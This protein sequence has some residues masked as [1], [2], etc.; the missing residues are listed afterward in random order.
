MKEHYSVK[1]IVSFLQNIPVRKFIYRYIEA[2]SPKFI[3]RYIE[4]FFVIVGHIRPLFYMKYE[5]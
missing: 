1:Y 5:Y 2:S 4:V 3:N